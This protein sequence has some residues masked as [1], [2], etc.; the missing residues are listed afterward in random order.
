MMSDIV[1]ALILAKLNLV[2]MPRTF[3][4]IRGNVFLKED[5]G[6]FKG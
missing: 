1:A 2:M 4:Q 5:F 6:I 3:N